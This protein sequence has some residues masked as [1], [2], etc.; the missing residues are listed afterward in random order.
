LY[1]IRC[2]PK[3]VKRKCQITASA[4]T[5]RRLQKCVKTQSW[6][7]EHHFMKSQGHGV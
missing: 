5:I 7:S 6:Q 2:N 4:K 1:P 3:P